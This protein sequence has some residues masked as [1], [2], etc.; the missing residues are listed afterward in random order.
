MSTTETNSGE[1]PSTALDTRLV[2]A[3]T[4]VEARRVPGRRPTSTLALAASRASVN[5]E[6]LGSV[7]C[8]RACWTSEIAMMERSSSPSRARRVVECS[9]QSVIPK[10][11]LVENLESNA[12]GLGQAR[13]GHLQA[14]L[15]NLV[16]GRQQLGS[17]VADFI[18]DAGFPQLLHDGAGVFRRQSGVQRPHSALALPA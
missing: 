14:Q 8:T 12:P 5:T 1:R 4:L 13:S 15:W 7:T 3:T 2:I 18:I 6:S 17:V 16:L 10:F 9:A 11:S